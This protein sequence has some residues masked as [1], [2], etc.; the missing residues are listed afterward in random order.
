VRRDLLILL[1]VVAAGL[2]LPAAVG[3]D[4]YLTI[5]VMVTLNAMVVNGLVLLM[6]YAGQVSIGHAAF[7]G[8]GAY[9]TG[10]LTTRYRWPIPAGILA[11]LI[12]TALVAWVVGKPALRLKG[13]YLAMATLA[14][15]EIIHIAFNELDFLTGG[16]S[17]LSGIPRLALAG[18][19]FDSDRRFYFLCLGVLAL[20]LLSS[21]N[22]IHSRPGRGLLAIHGSERAAQAM[23]VDTAAFKTAVFVIS[24]VYAALAG[25]LYAHFITFISPSSFGVG[26]SVLLVTMVAIGGMESVW[27]GLVGA[28][29]LTIL[30]E[31][32][33]VFRD[34]DILIYGAILMT[35]MIF[36]PRGL[37]IGL[38]EGVLHL[39]RRAGRRVASP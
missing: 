16:P 5:M 10:I 21:L 33:R 17:G 13:H 15:G 26:A 24:A 4:Y 29:V 32:L 14:I 8:L 34:Y 39:F 38:P 7:Y 22:I 19:S 1:G 23:G 3:N 31:Y 35:I 6:G 9:L 2:I 18:I 20:V 30:P 25:A 36:M 37:V 11:A 28:A 12:L 27:G